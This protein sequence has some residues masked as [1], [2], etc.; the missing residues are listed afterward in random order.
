MTPIRRRLGRPWLWECSATVDERMRW[1]GIPGVI[2]DGLAHVLV[3]PEEVLLWI[4]VV[5]GK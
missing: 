4:G 1:K 2:W 5:E 3:V